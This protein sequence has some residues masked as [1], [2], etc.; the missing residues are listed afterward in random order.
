MEA[1][2]AHVH[3]RVELDRLPT[4]AV[5]DDALIGLIERPSGRSRF[6]DDLD[7]RVAKKDV[8]AVDLGTPTRGVT[9]ETERRPA[10]YGLILVSLTQAS[11]MLGVSRTTIYE[12]LDAGQLRSVKL[13]DRGR[14]RRIPVVD[15]YAVA[16]LDPDEAVS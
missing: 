10:K 9:H 16:G 4:P 2:H 12:L 5:G 14:T 11:N 3:R 8:T 15:I 13:G 1:V 6:T 7:V